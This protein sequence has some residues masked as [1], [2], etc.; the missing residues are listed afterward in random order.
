MPPT[1]RLLTCNQ[2]VL[3]KKLSAVALSLVLVA[4]ATQ[5]PP[6]PPK[7]A[8]P[9][10][11]PPTSFPTPSPSS[12]GGKVPPVSAPAAEAHARYTAA[13]WSQLPGWGQD[14][15]AEGF[16]AWLESCKTLAKRAGWSSA[17]Q[18]AQRVDSKQAATVR[19]YYEAH[20][21]P[22]R[23]SDGDKTSGLVTGYYEPLLKGNTEQTS[24]AR[25][26]LYRPPADLITVDLG[27]A[28]PELKSLRLRGRLVGNKL[29]PYWSRAEIQA[30]KGVSS[31]DVL[32]WADDP[33]ALFFLQ[34]Q[35]SGRI[36]LPNGDQLRVGYADQNGYPYKSIGKWLIDR[37]EIT[38]G[39]A[40]MQGIQQWARA[41][42]SRLNE[43]LANNP[44]Y[45]FFRKLPS[46]TG[47]PLGAMGVPL[48]NG[49]SIAVD[50]RYTP[51]GT[52]VWL[53][54]TYP[55][56]REP[57]RRLV[58]AQ[59]TGSAIK[60]AVRADFFWGFGDQAG[61][62]AGRMRQAGEMWLLLPKG[63]APPK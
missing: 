22:W 53:A 9:P 24:S 48:T 33:I 54:T 35:G 60:G 13:N 7:S 11:S 25:Y 8:S 39:Q 56:S 10:P 59:D 55:A 3:M 43:L 34:V 41:N 31:G 15:P 12:S 16:G 63:V 46:G 21:Q 51:L 44:S 29:V 61:E 6:A 58:Y 62:Q 17:C 20:F 38:A 42:P 40:T 37:G 4:C 49:H 57:L 47:G 1:G 30:G 36:A 32:A 26:P 19:S 27:S 18:A 52:P 2:G 14:N 5:P 45:V 50:P 23:L 28:Y